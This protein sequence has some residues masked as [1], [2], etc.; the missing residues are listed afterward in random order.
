VGW[1]KLNNG[2]KAWVYVTDKTNVALI[3]TNEYDILIST[4][5]FTGITEALH[6]TIN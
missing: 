6:K 2:N 3:P 4:D 5:D 1:M